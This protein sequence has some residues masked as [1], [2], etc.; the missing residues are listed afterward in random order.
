MTYELFNYPGQIILTKVTP[1]YTNQ[2]TGAWVPEI[3]TDVT[4]SAH[5]SDI[6]LEERKH[7]DAGLLAKGVRKL[8]CNASAAVMTGDRITIT[9]EDSTTS[10]WLVNSK[11]NESNLMKTYVNVSRIAY[12]L[13]KR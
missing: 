2:T 10:T 1:G 3:T 7:V 5:I 8:T 12:L 9:E 11:M 13:E 6:T 4:I